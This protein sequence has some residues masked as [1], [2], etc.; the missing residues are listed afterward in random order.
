MAIPNPAP[1]VP[2]DSAFG[3][4]QTTNSTTRITDIELITTLG[5]ATQH[6]RMDLRPGLFER[7]RRRIS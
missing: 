1:V 7:L 5:E 6:Q 4:L 2:T 3:F